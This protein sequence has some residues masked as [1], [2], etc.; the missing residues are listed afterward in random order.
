MSDQYK[1]CKVYFYTKK[2]FYQIM[3]PCTFLSDNIHQVI[4]WYIVKLKL[5]QVLCLTTEVMKI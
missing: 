1:N 3:L 4:L 2:S 5:N